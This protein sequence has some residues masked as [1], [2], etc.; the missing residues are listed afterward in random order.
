M[1]LEEKQFEGCGG[2]ELTSDIRVAIAVQASILLL[3]RPTRYFSRLRTVLVYPREYVDREPVEL[4]DGTVMEG[5]DVRLGESWGDAAVV[6]LAWDE[7]NA[8]LRHRA[9]GCNVVLHEF[10]HQLDAETG[11]D[12]G[13]PHLATPELASRWT[14]VFRREY[15]AHR[16]A[17]EANAPT[18]IDPYGAEHPAEF[19]AVV[20]ESFFMDS[21]RLRHRHPELHEL[22]VLYYG[23]DPFTQC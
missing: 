23:L 19:F 16:E 13:C 1:L 12:D 6:V 15:E 4:E 9:D 8:G 7:V 10:A 20:T 14:E 21:S 17:V 18:A 22:L 11:A 3:G 2:L 5:E